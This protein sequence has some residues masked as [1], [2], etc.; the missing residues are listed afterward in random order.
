MH[1]G[2]DNFV[3]SVLLTSKQ[4]PGYCAPFLFREKSRI[5]HHLQNAHRQTPKKFLISIF[6]FFWNECK[7]KAETAFSLPAMFR[8]KTG[9]SAP[10]ASDYMKG[11]EGLNPNVKPA[12]R[13]HR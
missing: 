7:W 1:T 3:G 12:L 8:P 4:P 13:L 6:Y 10:P 5:F 2:A 11:P 9:E